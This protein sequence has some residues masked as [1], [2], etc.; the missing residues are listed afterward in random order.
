MIRGQLHNLHYWGILGSST[1]LF[2]WLGVQV[3]LRV[4]ETIQR[5]PN[6]FPCVLN[7]LFSVYVTCHRTLTDLNRKE[8]EYPIPQFSE[9]RTKAQ[10]VAQHLT[11]RGRQKLTWISVSGLPIQTHIDICEGHS[12]AESSQ[13]LPPPAEGGSCGRWVREEKG[14][15]GRQTWGRGL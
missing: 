10:R 5:P 9:E 14:L 3:F 4:H 7:L 12:K 15:H 11:G 1:L 8:A 2:L 6:K 13:H